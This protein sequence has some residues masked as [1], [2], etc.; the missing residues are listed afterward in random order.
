MPL[1]RYQT[2]EVE[3]Q[4]ASLEP[5]SQLLNPVRLLTASAAA[6]A[7]ADLAVAGSR[8]HSSSRPPDGSVSP[9]KLFAGITVSRRCNVDIQA[10]YYFLTLLCLF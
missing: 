2:V 3:E 8:R 6:G 5:T 9:P 1:T 7:G 4:A 10:Y